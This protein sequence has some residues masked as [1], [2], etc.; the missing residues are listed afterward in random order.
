MASSLHF[1]L[2]FSSLLYNFSIYQAKPFNPTD[3]LI[4]HVKKDVSTLQYVTEIHIG[5]P[6]L[7][8]KLA[9]DLGGPFPWFNCAPSSSSRLVNKRSIQCLAAKP[10][11]HQYQGSNKK[12]HIFTENR[13]TQIAIQGDLVEDITAI[14]QVTD[15]SK[16]G[17]KSI[18]TVDYNFQFSCAPMLLLYGLASGA[19]GMLGL[20]RTQMSM[21]SQISAQLSSKLQFIICLS[22][23]NG[24][25]LHENGHRSSN[26]RTKIPDSMIYTPLVNQVETPHEYVINLKSIK[27]SGKKLSLGIE[28]G[29]I[30]LS[31]IVPYTTMESSIYAT[32]TKAY[33]QAATSMNITRVSPV[34]PFGQCF[35]SRENDGTLVGPKVPAIDLV[36]QSEMVK[37]RIHG[38]NSMVQV[39][40]EVMCLGFLDGGLNLK[41]SMVIGGYQ[42]EDTL[43]H[44]DV[45][46]SRLGFT[47]QSCSVLRLDSAFKDTL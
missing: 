13:I 16:T 12:C 21:T 30:K 1:L 40:D 8:S 4:F 35:S 34:A 26:F 18:T 10:K 3:G 15:G 46:A 6:L 14:N 44:F 19:K 32:F 2:L 11:T 20:G 9:V 23:S 42:L 5:T 28:E 24:V 37:W 39:S 45:G 7:L 47:Q 41:T 43:L 33:E 27:I 25:V 29:K 38:R 22:S 31:T 36:L 17:S